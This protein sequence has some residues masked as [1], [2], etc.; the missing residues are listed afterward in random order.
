VF[1]KRE[2]TDQLPSLKKQNLQH[3]Q[4][5]SRSIQELF[6]EDNIDH[7]ATREYNYT[8]SCVAYGN[9]DPQF[10]VVKLPVPVQLS[11]VNAIAITDVNG[12]NKPDVVMGGNVF[13]LQPQFC[14]LDASY[15]HLMLNEGNRKLVYTS[16]KTSGIQVSGAV[17]DLVPFQAGK[18]KHLLVLQNNDSAVVY[19]Y[20]NSPL[21]RQ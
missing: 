20:N 2:L 9:K 7:A 18:Q 8:S 12:D 16:N 17:R 14:R 3:A 1:L 5:A 21:S 11:S 6:S 19:R 15:G 13:A 10:D 4:Y